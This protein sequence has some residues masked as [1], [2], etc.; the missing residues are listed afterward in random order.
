[1]NPLTAHYKDGAVGSV[2]GLSAVVFFSFPRIGF[3][4]LGTSDF[5][6]V[7]QPVVFYPFFFFGREVAPNSSVYRGGQGSGLLLVGI[8]SEG[9]KIAR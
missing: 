6:L 4:S 2:N 3:S 7:I 9:V 5:E 1:M 8:S